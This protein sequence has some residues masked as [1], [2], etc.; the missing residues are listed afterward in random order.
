MKLIIEDSGL[1]FLKKIL[2]K[3]LTL[4]FPPKR[5]VPDWVFL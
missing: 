1:V 2:L 5:R 4:S 3:Y